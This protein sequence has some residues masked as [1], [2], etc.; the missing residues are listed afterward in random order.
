MSE[1]IRFTVNGAAKSVTTDPERTL[2][3]VLREELGLYGTK[4]GCGEGQCGACSVLVDGR[5][6]RSC[7]TAIRDVDNKSLVTIEGLGRT[8]EL[9][10]VQ[11]AFMDEGAAQCGYCTSGMIVSAVELLDTNSEPTDEQIIEHMDGHICR[12]NGYTKIL[13][14]VRRASQATKGE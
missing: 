11:Q 6:T 9:H 1:V 4:Y 13:G 3:D 10:P 8:E 5:S 12:C 7:R 2:L 14:A